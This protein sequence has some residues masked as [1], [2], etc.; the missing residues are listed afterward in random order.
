MVKAQVTLMWKVKLYFFV[1]RGVHQ[2][3]KV[4]ITNRLAYFM[5]FIIYTW[6]L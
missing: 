3:D 1:C 2:T 6:I 4:Y 5:S